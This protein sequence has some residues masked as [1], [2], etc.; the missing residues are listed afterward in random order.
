MFWRHFECKGWMS[1]VLT[2][3][4]KWADTNEKCIYVSYRGDQLEAYINDSH[5][6]NLDFCIV[7][8]A[9]KL[10]TKLATLVSNL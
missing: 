4:L 10:P 7:P 5:S 3:V 8:G 2:R 1:S 9:A 6:N